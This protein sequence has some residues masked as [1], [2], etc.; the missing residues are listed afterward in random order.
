[1][2]QS[3]GSIDLLERALAAASLRHAAISQNIAN[4]NTPGYQAHTVAFEQHLQQALAASRGEKVPLALARTHAGH[5][6]PFGAAPNRPDQV[7][8]VVR[9]DTEHV[10]RHDGNNV[11]IE[12]EMAA[13]AANQIWYQGLVRLIS[14]QF[15][16]YRLA[17]TEG[18]R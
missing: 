5:L 17:I 1:M 4:V 11:D 15:S 18:R 12:S 6:A 9:R 10:A 7:Q 16:R 8:P 2:A 13:L 14:D 3:S